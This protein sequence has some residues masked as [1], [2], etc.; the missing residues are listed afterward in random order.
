MNSSV[1]VLYRSL[2]L[3][4]CPIREAGSA[5]IIAKRQIEGWFGCI[6]HAVRIWAGAS[7]NNWNPW[8]CVSDGEERK[9]AIIAPYSLTPEQLQVSVRH[10]SKLCVGDSKDAF[11]SALTWVNSIPWYSTK[12]GSI[13]K[14]IKKAVKNGAEMIFVLDPKK[15]TKAPTLYRATELLLEHSFGLGGIY[16]D[17]DAIG[18]RFVPKTATGNRRG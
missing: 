11:L 2:L 12:R 14:L 8:L 18:K 3:P 4:G 5:A 10:I 9:T 6:E 13:E 17:P 15:T 7:D 1:I 16:D